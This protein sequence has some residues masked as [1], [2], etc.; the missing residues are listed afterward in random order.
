MKAIRNNGGIAVN[1]AGDIY[2]FNYDTS[3]KVTSPTFVELGDITQRW[4][5]ST[6]YAQNR[7]FALDPA[8]GSLL[9][10]NS[11]G[12]LEEYVLEGPATVTG[13]CTGGCSPTRIVASG[14]STARSLTVDENGDIY[15]N[16]GNS[17]VELNPE[18]TQIGELIGSGRLVQSERVAVS[19]SGDVYV[20]D[21]THSDVAEFGPSEL[22]PNPLTDNPAVLDGVN[23][24]GKRN[25]AD[26]EVT[27]NGEFAVFPSTLPLTGFGAAGHRKIYRYFASTRKLSCVSCDPTGAEPT[28]DSTLASNGLSL[29]N[30]GRVFFT[31][32]EADAL[33]DTDN[34]QDVYEWEE[35]GAG[36]CDPS[37]P[38]Y[39]PGA[40]EC[41]SLISS[42]TSAFDSILL[43]VS[44]DGTDAFFFTRDSLVPQDENGPLAKLYDARELGGFAFKP[45]I[46]ACKASDECH[47][48]GSPAP[49]LPDIYG[50]K[51]SSGNESPPAS[52][53]CKAGFV[54]KHGKCVKKS[55]PH[56]HPKRAAKH[57]RGDRK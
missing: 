25:T 12:E 47:G 43:G 37:S 11:T 10:L 41:L 21:P 53:K 28:S 23:A 18:G 5:A 57:H 26:F 7:G 24:A 34:R 52:T 31:T 16:L 17:V 36:N 44:S 45:P 14:F 29:T 40:N 35:P 27:P 49:P 38:N 48:P 4:Q 54:R 50:N 3:V 8:K 51:S 55:K 1:A 42:G 33:R 30:D 15:I 6:G 2:R 32:A 13:G 20:D 19:S 9:Q 22:A 46:P 56:K 39:S